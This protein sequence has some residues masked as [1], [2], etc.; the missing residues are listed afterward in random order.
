MLLL[1]DP[2]DPARQLARPL[3]IVAPPHQIGRIH[4]TQFIV[5][6][7]H[8]LADLTLPFS[9]LLYDISHP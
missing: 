6:K 2:D 9:R 5:G 3:L 7:N 4:P 1:S 8:G